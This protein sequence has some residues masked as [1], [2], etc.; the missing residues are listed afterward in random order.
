MNTKK[1]SVQW[2]P[3]KAELVPVIFVNGL[4][5]LAVDRFLQF[6]RNNPNGARYSATNDP[7]SGKPVMVL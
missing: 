7:R 2:I 5:L 4:E 6:V 3:A 1:I